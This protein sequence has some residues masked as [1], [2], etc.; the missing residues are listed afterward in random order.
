MW[1]VRRENDTITYFNQNTGAK[2]KFGELSKPFAPELI[3]VKITDYCPFGCKFC[4]QGS[5]EHGLHADTDFV[6]RLAYEFGK[7]G[8]FE[9]AIG[10][11]E[12][13]LH[14][15]FEHILRSFRKNDVIPNFTTRNV[16]WLLN[17]LHSVYDI[18]GGCAYSVG[19]ANDVYKIKDL[20]TKKV[21]IHVVLGVFTREEFSAI[22]RA[23]KET[24]R[25]VTFLGY[26]TTARGATF[27]ALDYSFWFEEASILGSFSIDTCIAKEFKNILDKNKI[28]EYMY[29]TEEGKVS[30]YI[31]AVLKTIAPSSFCGIHYPFEFATWLEVFAQWGCSSNW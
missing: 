23:A 19:S 17:N 26:K 10:G 9:V 21:N 18:I 24:G 20:D 22:C 16:Q 7:V 30:C 5:T 1:K 14:P 8:V 13:T 12:P 27:S 6:E 28:P 4:Y 29:Y 25:H 11:G 2:I 3:D 15:D 31:D